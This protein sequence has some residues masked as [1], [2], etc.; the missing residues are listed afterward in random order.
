MGSHVRVKPSVSSPEYGWGSVTHDSVGVVTRLDD[1]GEMRID[2]P[3]F[4]DWMGKLDE[5][6][7]ATNETEA[8]GGEILMVMKYL[9]V[10]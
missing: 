4:S 10:A 2:F 6:E 8:S 7:L 9:R 3:E 5:M 1:D